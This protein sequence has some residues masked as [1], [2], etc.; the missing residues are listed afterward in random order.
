MGSRTLPRQLILIKA[1]GRRRGYCR[2]V[3]GR[4]RGG[5]VVRAGL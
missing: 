3:L 1:P 2:P 5:R 4:T